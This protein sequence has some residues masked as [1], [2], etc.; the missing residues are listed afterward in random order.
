MSPSW[1]FFRPDFQVFSLSYAKCCCNKVAHILLAK[2]V[3]MSIQRLEL[4]HV[5]PACV[6]DLGDV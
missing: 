3:L 4:W 6:S 5:T 2:Q 1:W